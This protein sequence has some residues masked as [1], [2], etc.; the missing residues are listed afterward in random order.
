MFDTHI[1]RAAEHLARPN[2]ASLIADSSLEVI[3]TAEADVAYTGESARDTDG[4]YASRA[5]LSF[6]PRCMH[7]HPPTPQ[8][9]PLILHLTV[10]R[11]PLPPPQNLSEDLPPS[12][13]RTSEKQQSV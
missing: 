5:V 12:L 10:P 13:L 8:S 11:Q 1:R 7:P 4:I 9:H 2:I 3:N 6:I